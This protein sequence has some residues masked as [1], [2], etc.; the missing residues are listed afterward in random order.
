[1]LC[2]SI[3]AGTLSA[4]YFVQQRKLAEMR[5]FKQLILECTERYDG[6]NRDLAEILVPAGFAR[7]VRMLTLPSW[8]ST[9]T[10]AQSRFCSSA[11][12]ISII[13]SV[14]HGVAACCTTSKSSCC[15]NAQGG[16]GA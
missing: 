2:V 3:A 6:L 9:L 11:K 13:A 14:A 1:M 12:A 7:S 16:A 15:S 8:P 10:S 4:L 5:L